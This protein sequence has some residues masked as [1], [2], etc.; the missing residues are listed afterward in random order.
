MVAGADL[1]I[2]SLSARPGEAS[3]VLAV[4]QGKQTLLSEENVMIRFFTCLSILSTTTTSA[5]TS[6]I[7]LPTNIGIIDFP[8]IAS[9][10]EHWLARSF[11]R[12]CKVQNGLWRLAILC[13]IV[14]HIRRFQTNFEGLACVI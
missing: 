5:T 1:S 14:R 10:C 3:S 4:G 12:P 8:I 2:P 11:Y 9:A 13:A 6:T 7:R